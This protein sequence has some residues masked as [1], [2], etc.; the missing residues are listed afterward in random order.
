MIPTFLPIL[1]KKRDR[2]VGIAEHVVHFMTYKMLTNDTK[3]VIHQ[4]N[5]R[6]ADDPLTPNLSLDLFDGEKD[7]SNFV[8]SV[9]DV[10]QDQNMMVIKPE[11]MIGR[12]FLA[13]LLDN[14]EQHRAR[15][16]KCID[17]HHDKLENNHVHINFLCSFN[18]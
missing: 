2:F 10:N 17:N 3:K 5:V 14:R 18:N 15:I 12:T 9:Q 13:N 11:D 4:S 1:Q 16:V 8:K 6:L 7:S